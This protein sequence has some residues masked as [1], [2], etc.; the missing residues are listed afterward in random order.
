MWVPSSLLVSCTCLPPCEQRGY[1]SFTFS[2]RIKPEESL[3]ILYFAHPEEK[4]TILQKQSCRWKWLHTYTNTHTPTNRNRHHSF[5]GLSVYEYIGWK[6][7]ED[8]GWMWG[9]L[10]HLCVS[11]VST[12]SVCNV[13]GRRRAFSLF[14]SLDMW[15]LFF[16]VPSK[17]RVT[18]PHLYT[19]WLLQAARQCCWK[20]Q[21]LKVEGLHG[22]WCA[23]VLTWDQNYY[24][25]LLNS[26]AVL[27]SL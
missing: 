1:N 27:S 18:H 9:S 26:C 23:N 2:L 5:T 13:R 7:R 17:T 19:I 6:W 25:W 10:E 24:C 4:H 14:Q 20:N 8:V 21:T 16:T 11:A 3:Y 15:G 22:R 12:H